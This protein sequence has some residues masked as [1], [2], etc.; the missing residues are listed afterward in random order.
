MTRILVCGDRNWHDLQFIRNILT[1]YQ[2]STNNDIHILIHGNARGADTLA[3]IVGREL[4][5][6]VIAFPAQ[7]QKFGRGAGP[8]RNKQMLDE[9]KPDIVIAFHDNIETS[10]GTA[11]MLK[12]AMAAGITTFVYYHESQS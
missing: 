6:E 9:G 7:W 10:K 8:I 11:H 12:I 4:G 5:W 3:G 1:A 2:K